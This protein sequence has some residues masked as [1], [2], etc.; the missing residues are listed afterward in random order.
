MAPTALFDS[1]T[2]NSIPPVGGSA[3]ADLERALAEATVIGEARLRMRSRLAPRERLVTLVLAGGFAAAAAACAVWIPSPIVLSLPFAAVLVVLYAIVSRIEFELGPGSAV[4][5]LL[6]LVPM[7]FL[8]PPGVVPAC[9][10]AGLTLGGLVDRIQHAMHP[11]RFTVLL[12]SSW[13]SI[14]PVLVIGLVAPGEPRWGEIGVYVLALVAMFAF[15]AAATIARHRIGRGVRVSELAAPLALVIVVDVSLAPVAFLA[16]A[17]ATIEPAAVLCVLPLAGLLHRLSGERRRHLD[18]K[19]V[20]GQAVEDAS[21]AA[22]SD[23][24][25]GIGNRLAWATALE[26]AV[27]P[28]P[29]TTAPVSIICLDLNGLKETNDTHG[30]HVGDNVIQELAAVLV[31]A[32]PATAAIARVGGDEFAVLLV[33][34]DE[35]STADH[36]TCLREEIAGASVAGVQLTASIGHASCPPLPSLRAAQHAADEGLYRDKARSGFSRP[37]RTSGHRVIARPAGTPLSDP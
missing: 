8:L 25:T 9:V 19:L 29:T 20:L 17:A 24:L 33:D 26:Q 31:R 35:R 5:T 22:H 2:V 37:P 32:L 34:S 3:G 12:C 15:D 11:E 10:A 16:G 30:H 7:L 4:P 28:A 27:Q 13:H 36:V 1:E 23:A 18:D 6:V 14:G 21:R